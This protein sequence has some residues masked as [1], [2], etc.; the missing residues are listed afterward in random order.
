MGYQPDKGVTV[1]V[2]ANL[3]LAP[4]TYLGDA[5]PADELAKVIQ[6]QLLPS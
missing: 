1:V 6:Q 4:N 2:L 3:I 5:L